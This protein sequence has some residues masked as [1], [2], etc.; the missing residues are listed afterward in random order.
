[1]IEIRVFGNNQGNLPFS[2]NFS[3]ATSS[4]GLT[5]RVYSGGNAGATSGAVQQGVGMVTRMQARPGVMLEF[6]SG[7]PGEGNN[8]PQNSANQIASPGIVWTQNLSNA[9]SQRTAIWV[10]GDTRAAPYPI[11]LTALLGLPPTGCM[12]LTNPIATI[13]VQT[14]GGGAGAG[15]AT[16]PIQLPGTSGYVGMSVYSQW[17]V[18]DPLA[19]NSTLAVSAGIWTIVAPV[20]G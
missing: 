16:L 15:V 1:L 14:V 3:G 11:D 6:G 9:A 20:G 7:C 2:F 12:L 8:I 17:V 13:A 10:M 5:T 19:M 4:I 18:F